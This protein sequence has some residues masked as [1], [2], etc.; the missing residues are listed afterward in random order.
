MVL[1]QVF[2][3]FLADS[4]VSVIFRATMENIFSAERLD[5]VFRQAAEQQYEDELLFSTCVDLLGLVVA[6]VYRSVNRA[7]EKNREELS[8]SIQAI[9]QKLSRIEPGIAEYLLEDTAGRLSDV[10]AAMQAPEE[11]ILPGYDLRIVD[12][13]HLAGTEHRLK[14]LRTTRA[15]ALP[16]HALVVLNPQRKLLEHL[17]AC[18]DG[19]ANQRPLMRAILP[20]V[21]PKQCWLEDRD[22]CTIPFLFGIRER[23]AYFLVHQHAQLQ[24]RLEGKRRLIGRTDSGTVYEQPIRLSDADGHSMKARRITIELDQP[25]RQGDTEIHLLTN[26][27]QRVDARCIAE[28]YRKR[29]TIETAFMHLAISLRGEVN[30]LAY[31]RAALF[32]FAIALMLYNV[33]SVTRAAIEAANPAKIER[34]AKARRK[35]SLYALAEEI[36][37]TYRGMRI[38]IPSEHWQKTFASMTADALAKSLLEIAGRVEVEQYLSYPRNA[39]H[40]PPKRQSGQRGNHVSTHRLLQ[41]RHKRPQT[42]YHHV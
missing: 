38:A 13:N 29:W 35:V 37:G 20:F 42:R 11:T 4:A 25:N 24:G 3:R 12:G 28:V 2:E 31:P 5:A 1:D 14:E 16:G 39:R 22:F 19:H 21:N 30:T 6:R 7:Y 18:E 8:V 9:Y 15:A 17:V 32:G 34:A 23:K 36:A 27:P 33:L 10:L 26:L 41:Q 40:P